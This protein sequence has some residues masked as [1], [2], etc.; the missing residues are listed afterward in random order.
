M[1]LQIS[2]AFI[3]IGEARIAD[4]G[5]AIGLLTMQILSG[6]IYGIIYMKS[7]SLLPGFL[8]HFFT[9]WRLGS[10]IKLLFY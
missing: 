5:N 7:R 1:H 3:D 9:D 4:I 10:I 6:W 8:A 2:L